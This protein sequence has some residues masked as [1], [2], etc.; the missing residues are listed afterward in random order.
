MDRLI[1]WLIGRKK[2]SDESERSSDS[3]D[4]FP[5]TRH[6]H[7]YAFKH[8]LHKSSLLSFLCFFFFYTFSQKH[9]LLALHTYI[10]IVCWFFC[11]IV[12]HF[13]LLCVCVYQRKFISLS[14]RN[15]A[16]IYYTS[17]HFFPFFRFSLHQS[18]AE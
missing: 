13:L 3:W 8:K 4:S 10:I 6:T 5:W 15:L 11:T 9:P 18:R 12:G 17:Q 7:L 1:N 16:N 2:K 14:V